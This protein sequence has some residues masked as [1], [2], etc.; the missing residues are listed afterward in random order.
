MEG[1]IL[2][3]AGSDSSGGAG[4]QADIKTV[5]ALH[6]YA[7][8]AITALTAQNTLG[9]QGISP[10]PADFIIEQI[11]SVLS[12]IG[13][14]AIKIG[15]LHS[16]DVIHAVAYALR[17][18]ADDIPIVLDPVMVTST[19]HKLLE[20]D[21]AT[22]LIQELF[23]LARLIT[24]NLDEAMILTNTRISNKE[25]MRKAAETIR[26]LG[27]RDV[28][29]KGGHLDE[30]ILTDVLLL[31]YG[32]MEYTARKIKTRNTHGTGCTYASAITTYLAQ[33]EPMSRAVGKAHDYVQAC[34]KRAPN[35][36]MGHGP[37]GHI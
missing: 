15:M 31:D 7:A 8:T 37:L 18:V 9:L 14:D 12:D 26:A 23:P 5:T 19:G 1:R 20:D 29:I 13:A 17:N 27:A 36:G 32:F 22:A 30:T 35:L 33:G 2:I 6:G 16:A 3:I 4:I 21:A 28:L 10:V 34:L 11:N 25:H 24:P